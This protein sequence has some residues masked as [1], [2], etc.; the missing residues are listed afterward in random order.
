MFNALLGG[1]FGMQYGYPQQYQSM[2]QQQV[3]WQNYY[4]PIPVCP[5]KTECLI[6]KEEKE[7]AE[8][9]RLEKKETYRK[10]C[11]EWVLKLRNKRTEPKL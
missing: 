6:C 3:N 10:R 9:I 4:T 2:M 7:K 8:K 5:H 11:S 1:A